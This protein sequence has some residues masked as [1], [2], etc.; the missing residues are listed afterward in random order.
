MRIS[1]PDTLSTLLGRDKQ[2]ADALPPTGD[3]RQY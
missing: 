2:Y 3:F 1:G